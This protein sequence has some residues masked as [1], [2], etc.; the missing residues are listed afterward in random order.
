MAIITPTYSNV[1]ARGRDVV[2]L[3]WTPIATVDTLTGISIGGNLAIR[4]SVQF[5][6]TFGAATVKLQV[7]NDGTT[8]FDMKDISGTVISAT[9]AGH[10][11]F[12]TAAAYLRPAISGGTA[13][14]VTVTTALRE[15]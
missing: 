10:F 5:S 12:E 13:D 9:A 11:E 15:G 8:Y 4:G 2:R 3:L 7:S 14:A 6:G 1:S